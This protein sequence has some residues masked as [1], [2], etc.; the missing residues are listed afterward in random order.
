ML[1]FR[2]G[3]RRFNFRAAAILI[4]GGRALLQRDEREDFWTLPGGRVEFGE[5]AARALAREI[6]EELGAEIE[7]GPLALVVE[8][9]FTHAGER[10]HELAFSFRARLP[11]D[12]PLLARGGPLR[13]ADPSVPLLFEWHAL[14]ALDALDLRPPLL[15][16]ALRD[17]AETARHFVHP[18]DA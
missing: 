9:F 6:A 3:D 18:D 12:S 8:N 15:R 5:S 4:D 14:D 1:S 17:T 13:G 7:V 16:H 10:F 11:G 2:Q